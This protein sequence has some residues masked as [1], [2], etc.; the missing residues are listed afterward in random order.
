M[1]ETRLVFPAPPQW[2]AWSICTH[3]LRTIVCCDGREGMLLRSVEPGMQRSSTRRK[4]DGRS[5]TSGR[6]RWL[7]TEPISRTQAT[8][9]YL[10]I[11]Q[12]GVVLFQTDA[13]CLCLCSWTFITHCLC[14]IG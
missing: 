2:E 14:S 10:C 8:P 12:A 6:V 3:R 13:D 11:I 9:L 7:S 5:S 1:I 4:V